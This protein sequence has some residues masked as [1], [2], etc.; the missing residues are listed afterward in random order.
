[1]ETITA[2]L[3]LLKKN[4]QPLFSEVIL[5]SEL[6]LPR[7]LRSEDLAVVGRARRVLSAVLLAKSKDWSVENICGIHAELELMPFGDRKVLADAQ[8]HFLESR[9][10]E[11]AHLTIT[12]G[13]TGRLRHFA[14]I[15]E[16]ISA[17]T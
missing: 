17:V 9:T 10:V 6:D 4:A 13:A 3:E 12:E 16:A 14:W 7:P 1:M 5:E 2:P 11:S 8:I 15:Q